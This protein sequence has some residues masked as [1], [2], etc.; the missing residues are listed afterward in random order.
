MKVQMAARRCADRA[1]YPPGR[2][3]HRRPPTPQEGMNM[4]S[5]RTAMPLALGAGL[6][7]A[8]FVPAALSAPA[9]AVGDVPAVAAAAVDQP[10]A[11]AA[12]TDVVA[13]PLPSLVAV[14]V[15]RTEAALARAA[16]A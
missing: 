16:T 1:R 9:R 8:A 7:A 11:R 13:M 2:W 10:V 6:V 14:R 3:Q 4:R 15:Q 12:G 5:L